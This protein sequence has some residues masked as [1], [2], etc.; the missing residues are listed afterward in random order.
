MSVVYN[1]IIQ[2]LQN[3]ASINIYNIN[4]DGST[5]PWWEVNGS[6][7]MKEVII[8]ESNLQEEVQSISA[9]IAHWGR[10]CSQCKRIWDIKSREYR[11]WKAQQY[12][13]YRNMEGKHTE[14]EIDSLIRVDPIYSNYYQ[15]IERA[16][17]TYN[18]LLNVVQALLAKK[19][20]IK[21]MVFRRNTED[22]APLAI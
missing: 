16:E 4:S 12:L 22:G 7:I 2:R 11:I 1:A 6:Y 18:T 21:S 5:S 14:K 17:E 15:E 10:Y 19:E 13:K 3:I 20:I 9:K 8:D